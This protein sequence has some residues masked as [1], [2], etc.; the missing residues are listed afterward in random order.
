LQT[1]KYDCF[2]AA[3]QSVCINRSSVLNNGR[4]TTDGYDL[5]RGGIQR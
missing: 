2:K 4:H 1:K 3:E 5:P